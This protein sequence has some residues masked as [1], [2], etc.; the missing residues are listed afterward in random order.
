MVVNYE[1]PRAAARMEIRCR[2]DLAPNSPLAE[3]CVTSTEGERSPQ[4]SLFLALA[5]RYHRPADSDC[6]VVNPQAEL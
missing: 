2:P 3:H 1:Y 4:W 6:S 5:F